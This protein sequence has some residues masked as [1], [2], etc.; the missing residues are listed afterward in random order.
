MEKQSCWVSERLYIDYILNLQEIPIYE[1]LL[2][3]YTSKQELFLV[4]RL[5]IY[6]L[7]EELR[8]VPETD[9]QHRELSLNLKR[10]DL[11]IS[12][13]YNSYADAYV[14]CC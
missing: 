14:F 13:F 3:S 2:R 9:L 5:Q 4:K 1:E 10:C 7:E 8:S 11:E 6:R 12:Q